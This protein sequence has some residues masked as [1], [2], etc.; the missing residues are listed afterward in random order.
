MSMCLYLLIKEYNYS[1]EYD[2]KKYM[3]RAWLTH[4]GSLF[5]WRV[6]RDQYKGIPPFYE[7]NYLFSYDELKMLVDAFQSLSEQ[8]YDIRFRLHDE[9]QEKIRANKRRATSRELEAM[10]RNAQLEWEQDRSQDFEMIV[11]RMVDEKYPAKKK[12]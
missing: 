4:S 12:S 9:V 11:W 6:E 8:D 1:V 10:F 2:G 3:N 7:T 5:N